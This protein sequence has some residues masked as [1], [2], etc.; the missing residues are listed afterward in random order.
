MV[1]NRLDGTYFIPIYSGVE[2][3]DRWSL[4]V[5]HK[6]RSRMVKGR[7][8]DSL[9]GSANLEDHSIAKKIEC[10]FMPGRDRFIWVPCERRRQEELECSPRTYSIQLNLSQDIPIEDCISAATL[11]SVFRHVLTTPE[12]I[13]RKW[14][15]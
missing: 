8:L 12:K 2:T 4:C 3:G 15:I 5:I 9:L 13:R 11:T 10:A 7:C 14:F 6:F 1:T